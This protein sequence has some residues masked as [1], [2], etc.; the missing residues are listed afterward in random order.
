MPCFR[1]YQQQRFNPMAPGP[2]QTYTK[3]TFVLSNSCQ[4][5]AHNR[6]CSTDATLRSR[7]RR[8]HWEAESGTGL[9]V[10]RTWRKD[11]FGLSWVKESL[12]HNL[13]QGGQTWQTAAFF[14][15]VCREH[16]RFSENSFEGMLQFS[17]SQLST[18]D[19]PRGLTFSPDRC[20]TLS[21]NEISPPK[22]IALLLIC[23]HAGFGA[24][25]SACPLSVG[26]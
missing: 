24:R 13:S 16:G 15:L 3:E 5:Q 12:I 9:R 25:R 21:Q 10:Q 17:S 19:I 18:R 1:G 6:C 7:G 23:G 4:P 26:C 22:A 11:G 14:C 8:T 2:P 20:H